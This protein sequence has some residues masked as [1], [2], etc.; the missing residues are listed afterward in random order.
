MVE[1]ITTNESLRLSEAKFSGIISISADAIISVDDTQRIVIFN[2]GA[3]KIFGYSKE[4]ALGAPLEMLIPARFRGSHRGHVV[5]FSSDSLTARRMGERGASLFGLRKNGEEFPADAAISKLEVGGVRLLTVA[6]R[7]VTDQ[8]RIEKEEKFLSEVGSVLAST[9]DTLET[10]VSIA[11]LAVSELADWCMVDVVDEEGNTR[12]LEVLSADPNQSVAAEALKKAALDR[13]RPHLSSQVLLSKAS[14]LVSQISEDTFQSLAQ[15]EEHARLL[16]QLGITSLMGVPLIARGRLLGALMVILSKP[17]RHF[18]DP[19]LRL[20]EELGSRAALALEN[21]RLYEVAQEAIRAR[22]NVLSVVAHD[23]RNPLSTARLAASALVRRG[24]RVE[25]RASSGKALDALNRALERAN[26]LIDDLLDV[27][28]L[29]GGAGI[30]MNRVSVPPYEFLKDAIEMLTLVA[31]EAGLSLEVDIPPSNLPNV[32]AD[33]GRIAQVFSNL[34]GNAVKFTPLGGTIR[35]GAER[36]QRDICFTVTD[37]GDG[38]SEEQLPYLFDRFWQ[39]HK[40]ERRGAG[41]GLAIV[42][43]IVEAHQGRLWVESRAGHG[44]TFFFT[45]PIS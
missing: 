2:E 27:A 12:H 25:R 14:L 20:L 23:L 22:D 7:D 37:S 29:E 15:G 5:K 17:Q 38:I 39:A 13:S 31:S 40:E 32:M 35:L 10:I 1:P 4:Q 34:V 43:G 33:R 3:E 16:K 42:K 44:T 19:D 9:L 28:G 30:G 26:R 45:L 24:N 8:K 11:R 36:R 41:L 6:L 18:V 21:T